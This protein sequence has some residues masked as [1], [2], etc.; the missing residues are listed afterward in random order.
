MLKHFI[1][2]KW[3]LTVDNQ[4]HHFFP[5][6]SSVAQIKCVASVVYQEQSCCDPSVLALSC[7]LQ[8]DLFLNNK[9]SP[10]PPDPPLLLWHKNRKV[11]VQEGNLPEAVFPVLTNLTGFSVIAVFAGRSVNI[12]R[13]EPLRTLNVRR[14]HEYYWGLS[15]SPQ[16]FLNLRIFVF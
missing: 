2:K 14:L 11:I 3:G 1:W 9:L 13:Q 8:L 10:P 15:Q 4:S 16:L 7:H 6:C 12:C 5:V